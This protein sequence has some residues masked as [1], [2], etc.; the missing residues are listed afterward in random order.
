ME[1]ASLEAMLIREKNKGYVNVSSKACGVAV[2]LSPRRTTRVV[3]SQEVKDDIKNIDINK[4]ALSRP[5]ARAP[6]QNH[7]QPPSPRWGKGAFCRRLIPPRQVSGSIRIEGAC[8]IP[9]WNVQRMSWDGAGA[10]VSGP[11]HRNTGPTLLG[12]ALH[13]TVDSDGTLACNGR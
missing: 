10:C 4:C 6:A 12:K 5:H 2:R 11:A 3:A 7:P 1:R 13:S 8:Y 9:A